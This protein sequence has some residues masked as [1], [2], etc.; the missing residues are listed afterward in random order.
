V[1]YELPLMGLGLVGHVAAVRSTPGLSELSL[2]V[3]LVLGVLPTA[4]F[5]GHTFLL[6]ERL[7]PRVH[8]WVSLAVGAVY[9]GMTLL[10]P[11]TTIWQALHAASVLK[12]LAP[13]FCVLLTQA[14]ALLVCFL[15]FSSW[16]EDWRAGQPDKAD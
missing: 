12:V 1:L 13:L 6:E 3:Q 9:L 11:L 5:A 10:L 4:L 14:P 8:R 2:G 16:L 15:G 7:S